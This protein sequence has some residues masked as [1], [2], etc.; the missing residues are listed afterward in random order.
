MLA[1]VS[2]SLRKNGYPD[3]VEQDEK[4]YQ[5]FLSWLEK[6]LVEE[7]VLQIRQF[8]LN[9]RKEWH[10]KDT[11]IFRGSIQ[12]VIRLISSPHKF[13]LLQQRFLAQF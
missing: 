11:N 8:C 6:R 13:K 1:I 12:L 7:Y 9:L 2:Y 4:A 5:T 3:P 10:H